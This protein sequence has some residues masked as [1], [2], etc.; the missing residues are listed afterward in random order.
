MN[1]GI[2]SFGLCKRGTA[3]Y[4]LG[5]VKQQAENGAGRKE[6]AYPYSTWNTALKVAS[7]VSRA[8]GD[9]TEVSKAT[10]AD[11]LE[12]SESSPAFS[13]TISTSKVFGLIQGWGSYKLTE[14][15][16]AYFFPKSEEERRQ[17]SLACL[18][19]P[20]AF[21][22]LIE[23]F[24]GSQLPD[25]ARLANILL[26]ETTGVPKSWTERAAKFFRNAVQQLGLLDAG[27][28]LRYRAAKHAERHS[29]PVQTEASSQPL[30]AQHGGAHSDAQKAEDQTITN[31]W[32]FSEAGGTV[33]LETPDPLPRALWERLQKYVQAIEPAKG[34]RGD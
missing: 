9:R 32:T 20:S 13:Q 28:H 22:F 18:A 12:M 31:K 8:G 30:A 15:G 34:R 1:Y 26:R 23:R 5:M 14:N 3:P 33:R 7:A 27:G 19:A 25:T 17:A 10:L 29:V 24:D 6:P 4:N 2:H 16:K 11:Y 21:R